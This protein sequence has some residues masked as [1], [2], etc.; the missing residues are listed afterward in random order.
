MTIKVLFLCPH[1]AGKSI[2]AATYFRAAA[3]RLGLDATA[4]VAGPEPEHDLGPRVRQALRD[5]GFV[6]KW[7]PRL[8]TEHDTAHA[9]TIINI[10]CDRSMIPTDNTVIEWD[11]PLLTDDFSGSMEAIHQLA[12]SLAAHLGAVTAIRQQ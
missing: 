1:A 10:G 8:V 2:L 11:V 4:D 6:E 12:E 7:Q 3:A 9:D 5:Q